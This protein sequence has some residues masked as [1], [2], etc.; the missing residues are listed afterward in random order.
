MGAVQY[1]DAIRADMMAHPNP[2]MLV[3]AAG[4][5]IVALIVCG[6]VAVVMMLIQ[7]GVG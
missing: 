2:F 5:I 7:S 6:G 3:V 1:R 4:L